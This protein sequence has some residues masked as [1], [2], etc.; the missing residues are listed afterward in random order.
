[1]LG[2]RLETRGST[3]DSATLLEPAPAALPML[4][5]VEPELLELVDRRYENLQKATLAGGGISLAGQAKLPS[6]TGGW[7]HLPLISR[8]KPGECRRHRPGTMAKCGM[9]QAIEVL[10]QSGP[11]RLFRPVKKS[12]SRKVRFPQ[13]PQL[14]SRRW[15]QV[16]LISRERTRR[17]RHPKSLYVKP[18][19]PRWPYIQ[20]LRNGCRTRWLAVVGA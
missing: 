16:P 1:M 13:L 4:A 9:I 8:R 12:K 20:A 14:G 10:L 15:R 7:R 19:A 18:M 5:A 3:M 2:I 6:F 17:R 11:M